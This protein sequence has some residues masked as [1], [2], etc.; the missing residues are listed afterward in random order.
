[1]GNRIRKAA[2]RPCGESRTNNS[3]NNDLEE[4]DRIG[5]E[6]SNK[7]RVIHTTCP[8]RNSDAAWCWRSVQDTYG[9]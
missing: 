1:M 3:L 8:H 6:I 5:V 4:K 9:V 7:H 2:C